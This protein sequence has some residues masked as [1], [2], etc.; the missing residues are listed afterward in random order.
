MKKLLLTILVTLLSITAN[1]AAG[2]A[3]D[4]AY[5]QQVSKQAEKDLKKALSSNDGK[6]TVDALIRYGLA[7]TSIS[8]DNFPE[9][10]EKIETVL[11]NEKEPSTRSLLNLLLADIYANVYNTDRY[12]TDQRTSLATPGSDITLWSGSQFKK[13]IMQ[14]IAEA[15]ADQNQL[16]SYRLS[17]FIDII[18]ADNQTLTSYPTL[19]DFVCIHSMS[20]L[21]DI[22]ETAPILPLSRLSSISLPKPLPSAMSDA[23]KMILEIADKWV[24]A[25]PSPGAARTTALLERFRRIKSNT[26]DSWSDNNNT[27]VIDALTC[28]Y[29][30]NTESPYAIEFII[31]AAYY[32]NSMD[33]RKA[34][35]RL[36]EEFAGE[37]PEYI[38]IN[39]VKNLLS[40]FSNPSI[41]INH[42]G[43]V[44][45]GGNFDISVT[46]NN[47]GN[48]KIT[49]YHISDPAYSK[50]YY[51][52]S[53]GKIP[54]P[55]YKEIPISAN[56]IIPF[57]DTIK[58]ETSIDRYGQYIIVPSIPGTTPSGNYNIV[59]CS[60]IALFDCRIPG[61]SSV[62]A[63]NASTGAPSEGVT[64]EIS[65][66]NSKGKSIKS[67][68]VI[69]GNDG[70]AAIEWT[71]D[72]CELKAKKGSDIYSP[73]LSQWRM[74]NDTATH[75][76]A[77][78]RTALPVYHPGDT[79]RFVAALYS[80][81]KDNRRRPCRE[82]NAYAILKDANS[83]AIDTLYLTSDNFGR[84]SGSF[85]IPKEGLTGNFLLAISDTDNAFLYGLQSFMVSDY[86]LPTFEVTTDTIRLSPDGN[87]VIISGNASTYSGFPVA[88]ADVSLTLSGFANY[89]WRWRSSSVTFHCATAKTDKDGHF[90]F[91]A[92]KEIL[93]N[94]PY[95][96]GGISA[97]I[98]VTSPSGENRFGETSFSLGKEINISASL[99]RSIVPSKENRLNILVEDM[100]GRP[101]S[102]E[103]AITFAGKSDT[104]TINA[105]SENGVCKT[106]LSAVPSGLYNITITTE[107]ADPFAYTGLAIYR[108][109]DKES[110]TGSFFW[111][112]ESS[113]SFTSDGKGAIT[114]AT[115]SDDAS[116]LYTLS[117]NGQ[118]LEQKWLRPK[119][120]M[121]R[122]EIALSKDVKSAEASMTYIRDL[123][124]NNYNIGIT[125][126]DPDNELKIT[127]ENFRVKVT[128]LSEETLTFRITDGKGNAR[129]AAMILDIYAKSIDAIAQSSWKFSPASRHIAIASF[130]NPTPG[131]IYESA[132]RRI[133]GLK[134]D[135]FYSLPELNLYGRTFGTAISH[136]EL[137]FTSTGGM[138][139]RGT[140]KTELYSKSAAL[141]ETEAA[142]EM[143]ADDSGALEE[144]KIV[145]AESQPNAGTSADNGNYR[146]SEI[147][148]ALFLPELYADSTGTINCSF[149]V[150]NAN[151]TWMLNALSFDDKISTA[152]DV[153]QIVAS[154]PVMVFPNPPRFLRAGDT[155]VIRASVMNNTDSV[156]SIETIFEILD[157]SDMSVIKTDTV[158]SDI[159]SR[160]TAI[161]STTVIAPA[162]IQAILFRVRS[163]D[164]SYSDGEQTLIPI[165]RDSQE[166]TD[167]NVFYLSPDQKEKAV[168][169]PETGGNSRTI[170]SFCEN[171]TWEVVSALPGLSSDKEPDSSFKTAANLFSAAIASGLIKSNPEIESRLKE[172]L[173][174]NRSE[175]TLLSML[176]KNEDLKQLTLT[177]TP[178]VNDAASD[179][180]RMT[181]LAL[182]FD[183]KQTKDAINSAISSL[184]KFG[185]ANGGWKWCDY[186]EK[187]SLW[188]TTHILN[189]LGNLKSLG[190]LPENGK[191][192]QMIADALKY[193][194]DETVK[195]FKE[196]PKSVYMTYTYVRSLFPEIPQS[197]AAKAA[198]NATVQYILKNWKKQPTAAKAV[199]ALILN[200]NK[201]STAAR[202]LLQSLRE[203]ASSSPEHGMWWESLSQ[204]SWWSLTANAQTA[205]ILD[206]FNAIE[207]EAKEIDQIRQWL[208][209]NKQVQNWGNS[210]NASACI[211]SILR[212]GSNWMTKPGDAAITVNGS[213]LKPTEADILTGSFV[214]SIE[215]QGGSLEISRTAE[216]P[217]W[218]AVMSRYTDAMKDIPEVSIPELSIKKQ[219]LAK[220]Q[221]GW[222][223]TDTLSVGDVAKV[224]LIVTAS[225][226]MD[227]ITIADQRAAT[228]E[229]VIQ[230][231]R[232]LFCDGLYFYLENRNAAT[233]LF[234]D[235]MPKGQYIIEYEMSINNSG[236]FSSGIAAIQSQYT[237]EMTAHSSGS[238]L[239]IND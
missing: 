91:L 13:K 105:L 2:N 202:S 112:P 212:S 130:N 221:Q 231:P 114:Y 9:V 174:S 214:T 120:G 122:L 65:P 218:G 189:M 62:W 77:F 24:E 97:N 209:L 23:E 115:G 79:A 57:S 66:R 140:G 72:P 172:W 117:A 203:F 50:S 182:L 183:S 123:I 155:A 99:T 12:T 101:L 176:E 19:F 16:K 67:K 125:V 217:A 194:D 188:A 84:I 63:V 41:S 108:P 3:P 238:M 168:S 119:K 28:L 68:T 42:P 78:I 207:P 64:I 34:I 169:L 29:R 171:P 220:R 173:E 110:P 193:I 228:M 106:D 164:G 204:S 208:I 43:Q 158:S 93:G 149:T 139:I 17:D 167:S 45:K 46:A 88:D 165:L 159:G 236:S 70:H 1:A 235:R 87:G 52:V 157:P 107:G 124:F 185:C 179:K 199:S 163:Y 32:A 224:R 200:R 234:I 86:K 81:D 198:S 47:A 27:T 201:Y 126:P 178:W 121:N 222:I 152:L 129:S 150:P 38:R 96:D 73:V 6:A 166:V 82:T 134:V 161:A 55:V 103:I 85:A 116:I 58:V 30:Q 136:D 133:T 92:G 211:S 154:K 4:F 127:V 59:K 7:Q 230:T 225:R 219:I 142:Y 22:S 233:N 11:A 35:Y 229:P 192:N 223:E 83:T 8:N 109:E 216:I 227:Y 94:S 100:A 48:G 148:L 15:I 75:K 113:C 180:E 76:A 60:D 102:K 111:T 104:I 147:P 145:S 10:I 5:P 131:R 181:R 146:P 175:N 232:T 61:S 215:D 118:I 37:A 49:I 74:W 196:H 132:I 44:T 51:R 143:A 98:T 21:G 36:L 40:S 138:H 160:A 80:Y 237:P 162:T 186:N 95:P 213:R 190:Y 206:A 153:R 33:E 170:I 210:V 141:G 135:P 177:S 239:T 56:G 128:P 191:L 39:A 53:G 187:P 18:T 151:T 144:N 90:E 69:T 156:S 71:T 195:D 197:T 184:E 226:D 205:V 26:I 54:L 89:W 20:T 25:N 137:L 14:T 31:E